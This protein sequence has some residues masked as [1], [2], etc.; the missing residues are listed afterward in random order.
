VNDELLSAAL[1]CIKGGLSLIPIDYATKRPAMHLLP[2]GDD[3]KPTWKPYQASIADEATVRRWFAAGIQAFAVVCGKVSGGVLVIDNDDSRFYEA[4]RSAVGDLADGLVVEKSG[5]EGGGYH[6]I[7]RCPN[8]G[9]NEVLARTP[10]DGEESGRRTTIETRGEGG[11]LVVAPSLHPSGR[12]YAMLAGSLASIPTVSQA[13]ADAL[14]AAARDLDEAPYSRQD[15]DT[16]RRTHRQ[17]KAKRNGQ[18]SVIDAFNAA[19]SLTAVLERHGYT[20]NQH[21]MYCRPGR[22]GHGSISIRDGRSCHFSTNDPLNDGKV[23]SG[24]GVHDAFDIFCHFEHGGDVSG[25]VKA[26]A[27]TLGIQSSNGGKQSEAPATSEPWPDPLPLPAGLPAVLAFD[28]ALLPVALRG[29]VQDISD[30]MQCPPDY[31][32]ATAIIVAG[33]LIGRKV[34][35]RPKRQDDWQVVPNLFGAMV[36]RPSLL[37]SPAMKEMLKFLARLEVEAKAEYGK[38]LAAHAAAALVR[39]ATRKVKK[40]AI[41]QAVKDGTDAQAIAEELAKGGDEEPVRR[42]YLANDTTVEKLG[43]I[44]AEN[45]NGILLH[46]D[47]LISLLRT[48]DREGHEGDRGFY[49]TAWAGDSRY[50]YDRIGRGTL[51][52]EAAIVS[53]VGSIQPGVIADYL[54]SAIHGGAGDDGLIQ[55]FQMTVWPDL[56]PTWR[57]IDRYPNASEKATA[58]AALQRLADL[59]PSDV[60]AERDNYDRDA[61][62]FLRFDRDGQAL[63]NS[64]RADLEGRLRGGSEH[65]AIE[66]HLAKY[67]SLIPSLALILHLLDGGVGPVTAEAAGKAIGWG[68]YLESHAR[69]LYAGVTEAPAVAARLL[70]ARI[71]RGDVSSPFAARDVYRM[72]WAGLDRERTETALDVLLSLR[73][74]EERFE[75]TAGRARTRYVVNPKIPIPLE[76]ELTKPTEDP[77]VSFVSPGPEDVPDF[78]L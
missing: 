19:Q 1:A 14:L 21:G 55:R 77:S 3:G 2:K 11:Y 46:M 74:I 47:E 10:D 51:D 40:D 71:Q 41:K 29:W 73:W 67:R 20:P 9:G 7:F 50:T 30:R 33:A 15:Q 66:S 78:A 5:R 62:P 72:G 56:P 57:N 69:R 22:E 52:I 35:I 6:V 31:C 54:R 37:K 49:L 12:R 27:A 8:P 75:A 24:I 59:V 18:V 4:W 65:P 32:A 36:G 16:A 61:V 63:F 42:R 64:W 38:S 39:E 60:E 26:A 53:I 23:K 17:K 28:F 70:A 48:M 25:A 34:A 13:H 44:L 43:M 58:H 68:R 76:N 45:P